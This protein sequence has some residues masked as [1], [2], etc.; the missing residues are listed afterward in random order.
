LVDDLCSAAAAVDFLN[1][2]KVGLPL[3]EALMVVLMVM[4]RMNFSVK[5]TFSSASATFAALHA[6]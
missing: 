5:V 1:V 2:L 3:L 4:R 6:N